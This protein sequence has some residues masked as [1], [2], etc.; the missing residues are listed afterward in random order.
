MVLI[1]L[2]KKVGHGILSHGILSIGEE[3]S[4]KKVDVSL[5]FKMVT[6]PFFFAFHTL[7]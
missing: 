6:P 2:F 5:S 1:W 3:E 4:I 7:F